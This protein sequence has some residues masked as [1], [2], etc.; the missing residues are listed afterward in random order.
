M[1]LQF[2]DVVVELKKN[3]YSGTAWYTGHCLDYQTPLRSRDNPIILEAREGASF[4]VSLSLTFFCVR[5]KNQSVSFQETRKQQADFTCTDSNLFHFYLSIHLLNYLS[6]IFP[7][8]GNIRGVPS[9][10]Y[11]YYICFIYSFLCHLR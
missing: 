10:F 6:I 3:V 9:M 2:R 7:T 8:H 5:D 11:P 1:Q 4:V